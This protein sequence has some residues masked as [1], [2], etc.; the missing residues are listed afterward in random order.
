MRLTSQGFTFMR[1]ECR[2]D[3]HFFT[4]AEALAPRGLVLLE[5]HM[6]APY[7]IKSLRQLEVFGSED[8]VMLGLFSGDIM[9]YLVMLDKK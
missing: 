1:H 6:K 4:W 2:I 9:S 7:F 8:A 3:C 5:R